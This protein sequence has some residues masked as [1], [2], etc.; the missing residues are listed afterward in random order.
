MD[1]DTC[2]STRVAIAFLTFS[3]AAG[4][5][6]AASSGRCEAAAPAVASTTEQQ[7]LSASASA[8]L[9]R[10]APYRQSAVDEMLRGGHA[11]AL[12]WDRVPELVV[13]TSVMQFE[14]GRSTDY[15]ATSQQLT[16][17]EATTLAADLADALAVLTDQAVTVFS[18]VRLE[19]AA[20]GEAVNVMR[21]GQ[22]VVARYAGVRD[23]LATIGFGGRST[24]GST[25]RAGSIILDNEFDRASD[26]RRLLRMHE[27]GH[28][29]GY[30]H[31]TSRV[32]I[33]NP[34]IGSGFTDVDR[35][36]ARVAF[37]DGAPASSGCTVPV[38]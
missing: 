5:A 14:K 15:R 18:A 27:L 30:N 8:E 32:S 23:Q 13:L 28:A 31:V 38:G 9:R 21:P 29:L 10:D 26:S 4:V 12:H 2:R 11:T 25:I 20:P 37:Q 6:S 36:I 17:E 34:K 35:A 16:N 3:V 7:A 19:A 33:M 22:I 1:V 24:R